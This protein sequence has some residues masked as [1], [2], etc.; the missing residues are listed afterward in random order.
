[1]ERKYVDFYPPTGKY[2]IYK[3]YNKTCDKKFKLQFW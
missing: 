3:C 2:K 1:M